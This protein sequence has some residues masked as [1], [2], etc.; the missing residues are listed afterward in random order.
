MSFEAAIADA[1]GFQPMGDP[2]VHIVETIQ[3][4]HPFKLAPPVVVEQVAPG[5]PAIWGEFV[6]GDRSDWV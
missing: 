2:L 5:D 4:D 3:P 1:D 6:W